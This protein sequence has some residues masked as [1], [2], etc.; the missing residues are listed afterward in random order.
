MKTFFVENNIM[1]LLLLLLKRNFYTRYVRLTFVAVLFFYE[2][3]FCFHFFSCWILIASPPHSLTVTP[4]NCRNLWCVCL[5]VCLSIRPSSVSLNVMC[6]NYVYLILVFLLHFCAF[7]ISFLLLSC[8]III[9]IVFNL[10]RM[11]ISALNV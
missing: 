7:V 1:L 3:V 5:S 2:C 10:L 8:P 6:N 11:G 9:I 4:N